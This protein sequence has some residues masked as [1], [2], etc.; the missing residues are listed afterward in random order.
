MKRSTT[1]AITALAVVVFATPLVMF[2]AGMRSGPGFENRALAEPPQLSVRSLFDTSMYQQIA[3]YYVDHV[4]L[5]EQA[6]RGDAWIDY[7][8]LGDSPNP[9]EVVF[10][11]NGWLFSPG[12]FNCPEILPSPEHV[13][14]NAGLLM[15]VLVQ[16]GRNV[17]FVVVPG[18]P[19]VM[20]DELG[21]LEG[22][23]M[24][25]RENAERLRA[26]FEADPPTGYL[27]VWRVM[28]NGY[29][30]GE[31][32]YSR[33][34]THWTWIGAALTGEV[35]VEH[36][37]P[38]EWSDEHLEVTEDQQRV[39]DLVLQMGLSFEETLA[40]VVVQRPGVTIESSTFGIP[41]RPDAYIHAT[42]SSGGLEVAA[43][44]TL[45]LGDSFGFWLDSELLAPF[46]DRLVFFNW[47]ILQTERTADDLSPQVSPEGEDVLIEQVIASSTVVVE[48][49]DIR[50]WQRFNHRRLA[51]VLLDA[52][53]DDLVHEDI[54]PGTRR[55]MPLPL[56]TTVAGQPFLV[57]R[58]DVERTIDVDLLHRPDGDTE[59]KK[60][61]SSE[62][63]RGGMAVIDLS[64]APTNGDLAIRVRKIDISE[65]EML[66]I[67]WIQ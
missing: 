3:T 32:V 43:G 65:V 15:S 12:T 42:S 26:A 49:I 10:G 41:N 47:R 64:R 11:S 44:Q 5:R 31:Q 14:D 22:R 60:V 39:G 66:R 23:S 25:A 9:E 2:I 48:A 4:P 7:H 52:L 53:S 67:V 46:T 34:D 55:I 63:P 62:S 1:L 37:W 19:T 54:M 57:L 21:S 35:I 27:D 18:K 17:A 50:V 28:L 40:E 24:C 51:I 58:A 38:G 29:A 16:S 20:A 33:D 45:L 8:F 13:V 59:W 6:T 61:G 36:L 56:D 30:G